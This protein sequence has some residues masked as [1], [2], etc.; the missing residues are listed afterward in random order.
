MSA[1]ATDVTSEVTTHNAVGFFKLLSL[2]GFSL[3]K[4]H[5]QNTSLISGMQRNSPINVKKVELI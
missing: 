4:P 3:Q 2:G 1:I 5:P